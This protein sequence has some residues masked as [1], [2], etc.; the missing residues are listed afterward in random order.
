[1]VD[2]TKYLLHVATGNDYG[3]TDFNF[4]TFSMGSFSGISVEGGIGWEFTKA[5]ENSAMWLYQRD[6]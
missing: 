5:H 6:K 3:V 1:M 2:L 4:N